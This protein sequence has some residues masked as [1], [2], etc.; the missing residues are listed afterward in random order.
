M[1]K[2]YLS[3]GRKPHLAN[4]SRRQQNR[5]L[6]FGKINDAISINTLSTSATA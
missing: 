6:I 1:Q 4:I 2:R 3:I 5:N